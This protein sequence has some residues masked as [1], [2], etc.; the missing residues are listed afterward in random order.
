MQLS[1]FKGNFRTKEMWNPEWLP[2][3]FHGFR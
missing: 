1:N 2:F 3:E